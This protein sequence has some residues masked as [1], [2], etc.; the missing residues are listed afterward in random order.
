MGYNIYFGN[1]PEWVTADDLKSWLDSS[2][3]VA[4]AIRVIRDFETQESKGITIRHSIGI[5]GSSA[6]KV[7]AY[8]RTMLVDYAAFHSPQSDPDSAFVSLDSHN[9]RCPRNPSHPTVRQRS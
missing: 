7:H 3:L 8:L 2:D 5:T 6:E 4:D 9:R 1:L